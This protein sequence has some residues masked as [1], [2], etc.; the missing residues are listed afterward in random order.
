[1]ALAGLPMTM[2]R[3]HGDYPEWQKNRRADGEGPTVAV[4]DTDG[5]ERRL[6]TP[7]CRGCSHLLWRTQQIALEDVLLR[8]LGVGG[9]WEYDCAHPD[10]RELGT[11]R[12]M[13]T[14]SCC[15]LSNEA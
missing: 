3:R 7:T 13:V 10:A 2:A 8:G 14:P 6:R 4:L 11:R 12:T 15:P 9:A 5:S 1:M